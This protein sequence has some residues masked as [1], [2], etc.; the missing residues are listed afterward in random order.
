MHEIERTIIIHGPVEEV[1]AYVRELEH[2]PRYTSG[3]RE[4]HKTSSGPI[5]VRST[6]ATSGKLLRRGATFEIV[7]TN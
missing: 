5:G 6:F 1:F 3:Q 4:A 7:D 2:A